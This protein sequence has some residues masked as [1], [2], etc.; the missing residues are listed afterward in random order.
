MWIKIVF[1]AGWGLLL[2]LADALKLSNSFINIK[3]FWYSSK[4][5][6][7]SQLIKNVQTSIS[8]GF[9]NLFLFSKQICIPLFFRKIKNKKKLMNF[10]LFA[11]LHFI[12]KQH[13]FGKRNIYLS[14]LYFHNYN[15]SFFQYLHFLGDCA[16]LKR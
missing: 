1:W 16:L 5:P 11:P 2:R 14:Q 7:K 4:S 8:Q 13:Q 3:N 12:C 10:Y 15:F 9:F 6:H